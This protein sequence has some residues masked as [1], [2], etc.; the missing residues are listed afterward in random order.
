MEKHSKKII[1][2]KISQNIVRKKSR[3]LGLF[4]KKLTK[5]LGKPLVPSFKP[6]VNHPVYITL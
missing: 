4:S 3:H 6:L 5:I 2:G 1:E